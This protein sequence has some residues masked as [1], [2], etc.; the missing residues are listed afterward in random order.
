[1][2][3]ETREERLYWRTLYEGVVPPEQRVP[4][5]RARSRIESRSRSRRSLSKVESADRTIM[6]SGFRKCGTPSKT[7]HSL[8][9]SIPHPV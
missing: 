8:V 6:L 3:V 1:M 7:G 2:L 4:S 9:S 5:Y